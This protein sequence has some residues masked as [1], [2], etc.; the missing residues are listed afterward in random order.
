MPLRDRARTETLI[1]QANESLT[2]EWTVGCP[3]WEID[4][5][6]IVRIQIAFEWEDM[7]GMVYVDGFAFE[8]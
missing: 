4:L 6:R 7:A 3:G 2:T 8:P 5:T 1:A